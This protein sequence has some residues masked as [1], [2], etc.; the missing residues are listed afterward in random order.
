MPSFVADFI[1]L[2]AAQ[3]PACSAEISGG[4]TDHNAVCST[5]IAFDTSIAEE[6]FT[7]L[8]E[9]Q[10]PANAAP[11]VAR[12]INIPGSPGDGK[13]L[14]ADSTAGKG[15]VGSSMYDRPNLGAVG[16]LLYPS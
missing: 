4:V 2:S 6:D 8:D 16:S 9:D 5:P 13:G 3:H 15:Y 14:K 10:I 11:V 1:R 12:S 7:K